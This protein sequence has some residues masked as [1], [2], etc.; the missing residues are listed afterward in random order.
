MSIAKIN[1]IYICCNDGAVVVAPREIMKKYC[2]SLQEE[3]KKIPTN[4][5]AFASS[6]EEDNS[7]FLNDI[8][9]NNESQA[10]KTSRIE[11]T[12]DV[13]SSIFP[14]VYQWISLLTR[15]SLP[16]VPQPNFMGFFECMQAKEAIRLAQAANKLGCKSLLEATLK[17]ISTILVNKTPSEL[18]EILDIV[19][20]FRPQDEE[21][22]KA[23]FGWSVGEVN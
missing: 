2:L 17:Y 10:N 22:L 1:Q 21:H 9:M 18:R 11:A 8:G 20:D 4:Y 6:P 15:A 23:S 12:V 3:V 5:N 7:N 14:L 16:G 19:N 13:E